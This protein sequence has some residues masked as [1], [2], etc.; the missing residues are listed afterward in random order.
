MRIS[1]FLGINK[2][3]RELDFVDI[4]VDGDTPLFL[5]PFFLSRRRDAWSFEANSTIQ[6]FFQHVI[7]LIRNDRLK[8]A[9][10]LFNNLHEPS[11]THL[12]L[13]KGR[14][15]GKGIGKTDTEKI[16]KRILKSN[17]IQSGL[18]E[19]LQD[20]SIFVER[21]GKDKLSDM[22][23]NIIRKHLIDYTKN[24]C[25]LW[26][27]TLTKDVPSGV[28]WNKE[29]LLFENE[30]L[31]ML[32]VNNKKLLL[33]PKVIVSYKFS[34]TPEKYYQHFVL[35]FLQNEHLRLN[36]SLVQTRKT[37]KG[38][39]SKFVT[40]KSIKEKEAP[41]TREFLRAFTRRNP[42]VLNKFKEEIS[43]KLR[44]LDLHEFENFNTK[45]FCSFLKKELQSIGLGNDSANEY[46][47]Y[48]IGALDF[49]FYPNLICPRKETP[50]HSGRK[51]IDLTFDNAAKDGFFF[52][53]HVAKKIPSQYIF[54]EC[55]NY[56]ADPK[57]PELDQLSGR[58]SP[59]RG[60]FGML[61]CRQIKNEALFLERCADT[62]HDDRGLI[63][64]I[65]D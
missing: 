42:K 59:N 31:E 4:E 6:S 54:I 3:Q 49:L 60:R 64:P 40:K 27:V 61:L 19:D 11:E 51:K 29:N 52:H 22:T 47:N 16:F 2:P 23:T 56:T 41:Y 36:S 13:S 25:N 10:D 35:N 58:F 37:K 39:I 20:S 18:V 45:S 33:V 5:D 53:L 30:L 24:Q 38:P 43:T 55:K 50:I 8:E 26:D 63:V 57:N 28:F 9:K 12:G 21:I 44:P 46:H 65:T 32:V 15:E 14:P 48:I 1:Q 17:A 62:Y 7:D 34:Y